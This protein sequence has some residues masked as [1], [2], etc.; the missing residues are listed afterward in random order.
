MLDQK[1]KDEPYKPTEKEPSTEEITNTGGFGILR[2]SHLIML[3]LTMI[4]LSWVAGVWKWFEGSTKL[5]YVLSFIV[6]AMIAHSGIGMQQFAWLIQMLI[7]L[8]LFKAFGGDFDKFFGKEK[9]FSTWVFA[10]LSVMI[11]VSV[12]EMVKP[13][14]GLPLLKYL[15]FGNI[16]GLFESPMHLIV[17]ILQV[18]LAGAV[19]FAP[20]K[21]RFK[22][23]IIIFLLFGIKFIPGFGQYGLNGTKATVISLVMLVIGFIAMIWL[24]TQDERAKMILGRGWG[25][26]KNRFWEFLNESGI[27]GRLGMRRL[28]ESDMPGEM[29]WY[30]TVNL[31]LFYYLFNL[32]KRTWIY[33]QY[34]NVVR[35][36]ITGKPSMIETVYKGMKRH[37]N[38]KTLKRQ[39]MDY[40]SAPTNFETKYIYSGVK[41]SK[42]D[43]EDDEE[44]VL[45]EPAALGGWCSHHQKIAKVYNETVELSMYAK[46]AFSINDMDGFNHYLT[47]LQSKKKQFDDL[48]G[49][50]S[51]RYKGYKERLEAFG[52][53]NKLKSMMMTAFLMA[54][55]S[56]FYDHT[57][58]FAKPGA[59]I[60]TKDENG[61]IVPGE[62]KVPEKHEKGQGMYYEVDLDGKFI[63]DKNDNVAEWESVN[64]VYEGDFESY[65]EKNK[66]KPIRQLVDPRDVLTYEDHLQGNDANDI[67]NFMNA[68]WELW[69]KDM[70][71]GRYHQRSRSAFDY[72]K[73][74]SSKPPVYHD[75]HIFPEEGTI[76]YDQNPSFD[77][78]I[79]TNPGK[80]NYWGRRY[81]R[82]MG[83]NF[84]YPDNPIPWISLLGITMYLKYEFETLMEEAAH[85][86][87]W[88]Q[89]FPAAGNLTDE[90]TLIS[91]L[92]DHFQ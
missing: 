26:M 63:D 54:N 89:K 21:K 58:V 60:I 82:H 41:T 24:T 50:I 61:K 51:K 67:L 73:A 25:Y 88:A 65:R 56:G 85:A 19:L 91:S 11:V 10:I 53:H 52:S 68:E 3:I 9:K 17:G 1:S 81:Y 49:D 76:V 69:L 77:L 33:Y 42:S 44:Y 66:P 30:I 13:G 86:K 74:Y 15:T 14:Y 57:Y 48:Q 5:P 29:P 38:L 28:T 64:Q 36:L 43:D 80:F 72:I 31:P 6:A 55:S 75:N 46:A 92:S 18:V 32:C 7:I 40:R 20:W 45:R 39:V 22:I 84:G 23:P 27:A 59:P 37:Y 8:G 35:G 90:N 78:R 62:P 12:T 4:V 34:W 2:G 87:E 16:Y 47:L 70:Q 71:Y 83:E 79:L